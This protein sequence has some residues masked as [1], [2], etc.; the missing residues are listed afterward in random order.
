MKHFV[1]LSL[2]FG[3]L[4][5]LLLVGCM[6]VAEEPIATVAFT[7]SNAGYP[8]LLELTATP[9]PYPPPTQTLPPSPEP[10]PTEP[11]IPTDPPVPT[12]PPTPLVT[13]VPTAVPPYIPEVVGKL[14][15]PFWIYYWLDNQIW[16]VDDQGQSRELVLDAFQSLGRW[17]TGYPYPGTDCCLDS[18]RV[19]VSPDSERLALVVLDKI[20]LSQPVGT[21]PYTYSIYLLDTQSGDLEFLSD[22][23]MP[24]WSPDSKRIAFMPGEADAGGFA[25]D[26]GLWI[27]D[28]E[29]DQL[30]PLVASDPSNPLLRVYDWTWSPDSQRIAY[31]YEED[32][33][34]PEI[35]I[36][37]L[38]DP[39]A[40]YL[41]PNI[42]ADF[43]SYSL[44]WMPDGQHLLLN[45]KEQIAQEAPMNFWTIS[46]TTGELRQLTQGLF[47][48]SGQ[49]SPDGEW[50]AFSA[51]RLHEREE[52]QY[53]IWL[54]SADGTVLM[55]L[56]SAPPQS[57]RADWSPDG[58]RLVLLRE[59]GLG[60]VTFSLE[61]GE[62]M[63]SPTVELPYD[64]R[65]NYSVGGIK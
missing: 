13:P 54:L 1:R 38:A 2:C 16:R 10:L 3:L 43:Y 52:H 26:N 42:P 27:A 60:L 46:V 53:D 30:Y 32:F 37:S 8:A 33:L 51:I 45:L 6:P 55:R 44:S 64:F 12:V 22:G 20:N 25:W 41:V 56:T 24:V 31:R 47:A 7:P 34:K 49:W 11:P 9:G 63:A 18:P 28:L 59:G 57:L 40:S 61:T 17:L 50:L 4:F 36:T 65:Y 62:V 5:Y 15:Q 58:T 48:L 23:G 29:T 39:A 21:E 14:Q 35:W 19:V